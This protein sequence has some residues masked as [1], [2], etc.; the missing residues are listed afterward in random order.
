[1][2]SKIENF[3]FITYLLQTPASRPKYSKPVTQMSHVGSIISFIYLV[4]Q[5][6]DNTRHSPITKTE[7][8]LGA[9][10]P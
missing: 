8:V 2:S 4:S 7:W 3:I 5:T 1:M 6:R 9:A 10:V